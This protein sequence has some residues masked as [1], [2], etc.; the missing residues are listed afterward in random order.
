MNETITTRDLND[1]NELIDYTQKIK[2]E[3][4]AWLS[5]EQQEEM[6]NRVQNDLIEKYHFVKIYKYGLK[7]S[8]DIEYLQSW[9]EACINASYDLRVSGEINWW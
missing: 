6:S 4:E 1:I 2:R 7:Y 9:V 3:L 5:V 8:D